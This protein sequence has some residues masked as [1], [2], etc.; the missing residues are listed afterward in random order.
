[1]RKGGHHQNDEVEPN[2]RTREED[3]YRMMKQLEDIKIL[4]SKMREASP[5]FKRDISPVKSEVTIN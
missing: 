3:N 2:I 5:A 1:M 4:N